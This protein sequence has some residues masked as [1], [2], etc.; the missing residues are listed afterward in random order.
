MLAM[1]VTT[2]TRTL[3]IMRRERWLEARQGED[4]RW[5]FWRLTK[6]GQE[7]LQLAE[8][9]WEAVQ[10]RLRRR[11]GKENWDNLLRLSNEIAGVLGGTGDEQ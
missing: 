7:Q 11:L 1:D 5:R 8:P 9:A 2:L 4:R 6:R 10:T 3:E